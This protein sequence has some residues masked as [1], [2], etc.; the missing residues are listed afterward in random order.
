M[1]QQ[2]MLQGTIWREI[3][4]FF[5]PILLGYL[6]QQLYNTVDAMVVGN[7]VGT[8]AL[9]AVGGSTSMIINLILGF[10][11]GLSTGATV[12]IAQ[13]IGAREQHKVQMTVSTTMLMNIVIGL[14][15]MV[16]GLIFARNILELLSVPNEMMNDAL[17]YLRIYMLGFIPSMIYNAGAGILRAIGDSKRPLYFLIAASITNIVL[18]LLLVA[19]IPLGV[20]GAAIATVFSQVVTALLTIYAF[21]DEDEIYYLNFKKMSFDFPLFMRIIA[22]GLPTAIQGSLYSFAN[23]FIQASVNAFGTISVAAFTAFGKIDMFFWNFSGSMGAATLTFIGQNFGAKQMDRVKKGVH[24]ALFMFLLGS[25]FIS[26]LAL[27]FGEQFYRLFTQDKEVLKVGLSILFLV[28]PFWNAV[29]LFEILSA[30]LRAMNIIVVPMIVSLIGVG[31]VRIL[32]V[33]CYPMH[34][35]LDTL[36]VY[37]LSWM[38]TSLFFAIYYFSGLWRKKKQRKELLNK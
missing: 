31:V 3:L 27:T 14:V 8:I 32:W 34:S 2:N 36:K 37:P 35:V 23:L 22:I 6:F 26:L 11:I 28:A 9:G 19:Y 24:Q 30:T 1:R 33:L 4:F 12:I 5:F 13:F 17:T 16:I 29:F 10:V 18:D 15:V 20:A 21:S 7:F 38:S 25:I